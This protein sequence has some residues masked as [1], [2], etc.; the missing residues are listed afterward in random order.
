S[1]NSSEDADG[2]GVSLPKEALLELP[3]LVALNDQLQR[4]H[5]VQGP[6]ALSPE[7]AARLYG[8]ALRT[9]VSRMEQ[10][11]A[12]PF[13]FFVHSGLRAEERQRF[14]LDAR[15]QGNFQHEVLAYFHEQLRLEN[16]RWRDLTPAAARERIARIVKRLMASYRDGMLEASEQT[17][18]MAGTLTES[19]QDFVET[20]V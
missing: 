17:R 13:E 5:A 4:L 14:E 6:E 18:F 1:S 12:C 2:N 20:L 15:E 3:G 10:F 7:L 9:S 16:L 11:A 8:P 19:L